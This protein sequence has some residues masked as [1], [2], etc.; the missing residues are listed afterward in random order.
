MRFEQR[1][2]RRSRAA[3]IAF[4]VTRHRHRHPQGQAEAHLRGVPAGRRH[5]QPQVRR[6]RPGLSISREIARLLGGEIHVE[7]APGEGS[8]FTLYLPERYVAAGGPTDDGGEAAAQS[9]VAGTPQRST[10]RCGARRLTPRSTRTRCLTSIEDDREHIR[11]GRPRAADH[12]GRRRSS[13]ASWSSMAREKRLQGGR[14]HARRHRAWRSPTSSSPDA[15]TL[16][17]QLPVSTAGACSTASSATRARATSRCT[18]SPSSTRTQ[19]GATAGRVRLPREAGQQGGARGALRPH[20]RRSSIARCA[21]CSLVED[22]DAA[23]RQHRRAARRRRATSRSPRC[24]SG[25]EALAA[26]EASAVRLHGR[27]PGAA[28]RSTACSLI[29]EVK[30][31]AARTATCRSSSTPART[32]A[33]EEEPRLQEATPSRVILKSGASSRPSGC[34]ATPRSSCTAW[35]T[36]PPDARAHGPGGVA[37]TRTSPLAGKK[38]LV[39]DD[40][41]RNIFALTSVLESHGMRGRLRGERPGRHRG[42]RAST[43]T[44]TSC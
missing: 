22:D 31:P 28:G 17:I 38:V 19:R 18:S 20:R 24:A 6:H 9:S 1:G 4:A 37:A 25:E 21:G 40:D 14:R 42:A 35:T 10:A 27:R 11:D 34:S 15:I 3:C 5:H 23:A 7:S 39:V 30:T 33:D 13:R 16:D 41:V 8:T 44:S 2:A 29:E 36:K 26:L 43:P 12:R 32:D